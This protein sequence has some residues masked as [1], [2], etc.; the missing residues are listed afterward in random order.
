[1]ELDTPLVLALIYMAVA[2]V[3][4]LVKKARQ[5]QDQGPSSEPG[6]VHPSRRPPE[7][8]DELLREMREQLGQLGEI[9]GGP[10]A[11]NGRRAATSGE[12][13]DAEWQEEEVTSLET[14]PQV[15]S[16]ETDV[17]EAVPIDRDYDD[18]AHEIVR[19]RRADA[20]SR[21]RA[22]RPADHT[23]FDARIRAVQPPPVP[24]IDAA[25][26]ARLSTSQ[27]RNAIV[28]K[29]ILGPPLGWPDRDRS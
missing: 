24:V 19:Q 26:T 22:W 11:T 23:A 15:V 25:F 4:G 8:M 18:G 9:E 3:T 28:W 7:T 20:E 6:V 2:L 5:R 12:F 27:L 29:E 1:M 16:L 21:N 14:V 17:V 13:E 10:A